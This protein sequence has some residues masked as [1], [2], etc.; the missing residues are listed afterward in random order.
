[1]SEYCKVGD[2]IVGDVGGMDKVKPQFVTAASEEM[3]A[4]LGYVYVLPLPTLP[5]HQTLLLKDVCRKLA[6]GRLLM[7]RATAGEDNSTHA[8]GQSL[9]DE[10]LRTLWMIR[11]NQ[12]D[13]TAP[14]TESAG[15]SGDGPAITQGDTYSGVDAFYAWVSDTS[16]LAPVGEQIWAPGVYG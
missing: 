11:N 7:D 13:L 10:A 9:V 2:L 1:M 16:P 5:P 15:S 12:I 14:K 8:Y 4:L 6:S 3:D